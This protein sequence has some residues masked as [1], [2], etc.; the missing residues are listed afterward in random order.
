MTTGNLQ[1][2][3]RLA[4]FFEAAVIISLPFL[5][6]NGESALRFDIPTLRLHFFGASIWMEEFFIMLIGIIFL[7]FLLIF[8]T[9]LFGRIW[10]G[11]A[12]PQTVLSDITASLDRYSGK[13]SFQ[14]IV[15]Y[16]AVFALS[17]A[18]GANLIWY[19]VS[20]YDFFPALAGWRPGSVVWAFWITLTAVIFLDLSFLRQR[21][22]ATVCPY[23]MLQGAL[24]DESTLTVAFDPRRKEECIDCKACLR[25]CPAGID[26]R[27][28]ENR[29]CIH[30][31][32]CIDECRDIMGKKQKKTL[33]DYFW[34]RPGGTVNIF[35][36]NTAMF[37]AATL[38]SL[39]FFCYLLFTR[40]PYDLTVLP[41]YSFQPRVTADGV[42][43][44]SYILSIKNRGRVDKAF[45][46]MAAGSAGRARIVPDED[47]FINAGEIKKVPVYI[48]A[49]ED[50]EGRSSQTIEISVAPSEEDEFKLTRKAN[51]IF[52]GE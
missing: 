25:A 47:V 34:G 40:L 8:L 12:C 42:T 3:R 33:I 51:F 16:A 36:K 29:A 27:Q 22:C 20:P 24:F 10:C 21:F 30:C 11:W 13:G 44:N 23:S 32:K 49:P 14:R 43:T 6:I 26:I 1:Q 19:F 7:S 35:R 28:G 48:S 46:I 9:L 31:A 5:K 15:S 50:M 39:L 2:W 38:I 17:L 45:K 52:S 37:G 41:N 18:A 4:A